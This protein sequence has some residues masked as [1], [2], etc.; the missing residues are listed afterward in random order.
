MNAQKNGLSPTTSTSAAAWRRWQNFA[1]QGTHHQK[2]SGKESDQQ[3]FHR[4]QIEPEHPDD[5]RQEQRKPRRVGSRPDGGILRIVDVAG[6]SVGRS[7]REV[8]RVMDVHAE[9]VAPVMP[10]PDRGQI[11]QPDQ[12]SAQ[13][14]SGGAT[15]QT[16]QRCGHCRGGILSQGTDLTMV[17]DRRR[18]CQ[19]RRIEA[20]PPGLTEVDR[21]P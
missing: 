13:R 4:P 1:E 19:A 20:R 18:L 5:R 16:D 12:E 11:K 15:E 10:L 14:R 7:V 21:S 2:R 8:L 3:N 17:A 9:V 6:F